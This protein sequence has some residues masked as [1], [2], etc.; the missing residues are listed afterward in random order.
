MIRFLVISPVYMYL[1][2]IFYPLYLFILFEFFVEFIPRVK[3]NN[4]KRW[5][6]KNYVKISH[7][8][9]NDYVKSV[10]RGIWEVKICRNFTMEEI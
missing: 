3:N 1:I 6:F 4:N 7:Q 9:E 5:N 8:R 2:A 10:T